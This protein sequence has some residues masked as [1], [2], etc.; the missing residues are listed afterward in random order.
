MQ[1]LVLFTIPVAADTRGLTHLESAK[2]TISSMKYTM[3]N[4]EIVQTC[5]NIPE[6]NTTWAFQI[7]KN[8]Q[9]T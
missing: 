1:P 4:L 6:T 9:T 7:K 2:I 3:M 5:G 8:V